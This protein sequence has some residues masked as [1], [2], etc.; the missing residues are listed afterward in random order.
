[1]RFVTAEGGF[2]P[3][4]GL[5]VLSPTEL[6]SLKRQDSLIPAVPEKCPHSAQS[7]DLTK[8]HLTPMD[9]M[10]LYGFSLLTE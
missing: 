1:M 4:S 7:N 10:N 6:L 9:K 2:E 8:S 3:T 5:T